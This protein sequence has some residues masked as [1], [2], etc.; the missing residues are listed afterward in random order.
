MIDYKSIE[1]MST[2]DQL[3]KALAE[4]YSNDST[5]NSRQVTGLTDTIRAKAHLLGL[6][7][8]IEDAIQSYIGGSCGDVLTDSELAHVKA[9]QYILEAGKKNKQGML[10]NDSNN[11]YLILSNEP[12]FKSVK[13][14]Q[15]KNA[16]ER[17][18]AEGNTVNWTDADDELAM[19]FI[20]KEYGIYS[21]NKY[22][23]AFSSLCNMREYNPV[24][25]MIEKLKWDGE[26][27]IERLF[28]KWMGVEDNAY[29]REVSR[30]VFAGGI[31]RI[32][33]PGCKFDDVAVL[34]G[35]QGGAKSSI[36]EWLAMDSA[37]YG[38]LSYVTGK[39]SMEAVEG[40]WII[41]MSEMFAVRTASAVEAVKAYITRKTDRYRKAY[42]RRVSEIPR[43]CIFIGSSNDMQF[44]ADKTGGRRF[45]PIVC[46]TDGKDLWAQKEE[47]QDFIRQCW[48]QAYALYRSDDPKDQKKIAPV[49]NFDIINL[50]RAEQE[51]ATIDDPDEG[52]IQAFLERLETDEQYKHL[53]KVCTLMLWRGALGQLDKKCEQKDSV[54]IGRIMEKMPGWKRI[55]GER[56]Y[57]GKVK[58]PGD[59]DYDYGRQR[60]WSKVRTTTEILQEVEYDEDNPFE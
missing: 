44:L 9:K 53:T 23:T 3:R 56:Y 35:K 16:P 1:A 48:A 43:T 12:N 26:D 24:K 42:A 14:N 11:Y 7:Q 58:I 4:L 13:Y 39:E 10:L 37:F 33:E 47:C 54:K 30:L 28:S 51:E 41:E 22:Q 31:H 52:L 36:I 19:M 40:L 25:Q 15:L 50:V 18:D 27:R 55:E 21:K 5:Y 34:I 2:S 17:I 59:E 45:Y 6:D 29:T 60:Y 8:P 20:E 49:V 46:T 38:E 57:F 32:Y